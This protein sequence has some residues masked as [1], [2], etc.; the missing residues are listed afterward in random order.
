MSIHVNSGNILLQDTLPSSS[1][2]ISDIP[3]TSSST[4]SSSASFSPTLS[5]KSVLALVTVTA[6]SSAY[7]G[8]GA[9]Q[10]FRAAK[11]VKQYTKL[12]GSPSDATQRITAG[13]KDEWDH[14]PAAGG[15][16]FRFSVHFERVA[17]EDMAKKFHLDLAKGVF[18]P[19]VKSTDAALSLMQEERRELQQAVVALVRASATVRSVAWHQLTGKKWMPSEAR[20][21][22]AAMVERL[23]MLGRTL[24]TLFEVVVSHKLK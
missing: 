21:R 16:V 11:L 3:T 5:W 15:P 12:F 22:A 14:V 20:G 7:V 17:K 6:V 1:I 10:K 8:Y 19:S 23:Q 24:D 9:L 4:T 18:G 2:R 13:H